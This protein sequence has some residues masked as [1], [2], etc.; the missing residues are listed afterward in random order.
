MSRLKQSRSLDALVVATSS[1]S[2]DDEIHAFCRRVGA[3][4]HRG[5][6]ED[7]L[8]RFYKTAL[9]Y[10]ADA[11]VRVTADN[12]LTDPRLMD[13]AVK[14][15]MEVEPDYISARRTFGIPKGCGCEII[16]MN[17]L[18]RAWREAVSAYDREHVTPYIYQHPRSF[19]ILEVQ[20]EAESDCSE[21][22][23]SVDTL[24]TLHYLERMCLEL[25][26]RP[27]SIQWNQIAAWFKGKSFEEN[28]AHV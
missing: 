16:S 17:A 21:I 24:E 3:A 11:V 10:K 28:P 15:H 18:A 5:S 19:S 22:D 6:L 7:V 14:R 25:G 23:L 12:P 27:D 4:C 13:Y 1:D 20:G 8:D 2:S 26:E 9:H